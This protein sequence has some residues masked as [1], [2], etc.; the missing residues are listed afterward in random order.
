MKKSTI[1]P[2][3]ESD[4]AVFWQKERMELLADLG[5]AVAVVKMAAVI[6]KDPKDRLNLRE[7]WDDKAQEVWDKYYGRI[8]DGR[9]GIGAKAR[10]TDWVGD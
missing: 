4:V 9:T 6:L 8:Q 5:E 3:G 1:S 2:D 10:D 7:I